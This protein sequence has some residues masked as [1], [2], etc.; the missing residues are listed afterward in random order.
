MMQDSIRSTLTEWRKTWEERG[1]GKKAWVLYLGASLT[2]D[3][4]NPVI[5][6]FS[7]FGNSGG[8]KNKGE[9]D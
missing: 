9:R 5:N 4:R 8:M 3:R 6:L 2:S 1:N 7:H